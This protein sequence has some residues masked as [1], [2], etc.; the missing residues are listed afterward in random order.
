MKLGTLKDL[1]I[2]T[3]LMPNGFNLYVIDSEINGG[4]YDQ[5][6]KIEY[7]D[8]LDNKEVIYISS[9]PEGDFIPAIFI[10]D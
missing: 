7:N 6:V 1:G 2:L 9:D 3:N 8:D 4:D 10:K 5:F